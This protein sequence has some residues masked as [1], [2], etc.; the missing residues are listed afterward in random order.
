[1]RAAL[2]TGAGKRIGSG[3]ARALAAA[4]FQV[5]LHFH[6]SGDGARALAQEI[7][8]GATL[9]EADLSDLSAAQGVIDRAY[10]AFGRL[11]L[12][13]NSAALFDYDTLDTLT[14]ESWRRHSDTNFAAPIFLTKAYAARLPADGKGLVV[15]LLDQK[16]L[17]PNPDYFAYTAAKVG[18]A[19]MT[20]ALQ[21]ALAPRI[22]VAGIAPGVTL[23][24][25]RQSEADYARAAAATP[26]GVSSTIEDLSRAL[27]FIVDTPS[28]GG[29]ILTLDGGESL[30]G[31]PR[32]VAYDTSV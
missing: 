18:L 10:A 19:H 15:N 20:P 16:V 29:Q 5:G 24:S 31:R 8:D 23:P 32:D 11:D 7:G 28:F 1:M 13:V 21:L 3:L 6:T 12:L 4:G 30:L 26:L 2:V 17:R 9:I 25:G 27:L 22:R 14:E